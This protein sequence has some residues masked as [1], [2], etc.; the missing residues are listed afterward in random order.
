VHDD[1]LPSLELRCP[2]APRCFFERAA[3]YRSLSDALR[4]KTRFFAAAA[5][6]NELLGML[7]SYGWLS[8]PTVAFLRSLGARLL[9]ENNRLARSIDA[10]ILNMRPELLDCQLVEREQFLVEEMLRAQEKSDA[11][12][13]HATCDGIDALLNNAWLRVVAPLLP[14][15][16]CAISRLAKRQP[17]TFASKADRETIGLYIVRCME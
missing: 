17:L 3:H 14:A 2:S 16:L 11:Y 7:S 1:A 12:L 8:N 4:S 9:I 5:W 15:P 13:R 10:G 6:I